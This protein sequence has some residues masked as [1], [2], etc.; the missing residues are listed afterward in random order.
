MEQLIQNKITSL[1]KQVEE[2]V[3]DL[4]EFEKVY[5][6]IENPNPNWK[7]SHIRLSVTN[8]SNS[9]EGH[10][11]KRY[12]ELKVFN[13]P[14]NPYMCEKLIFRGNKQEMLQYLEDSELASR[15][16]GMIPQLESDLDDI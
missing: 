4:G 3:P 15:I 6:T 14:D 16:L 5:E 11:W 10:E 8:L 1:R 12:F 2:K 9:I 13:M 7:L